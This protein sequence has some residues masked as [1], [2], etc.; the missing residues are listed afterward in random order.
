M[1]VSQHGRLTVM[2]CWRG[3]FTAWPV[4]GHGLLGYPGLFVSWFFTV[5]RGLL[6]LDTAVF[7]W[8]CIG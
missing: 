8:G 3:G 7:V 2:A 4:D 5:W 1:R 6:G